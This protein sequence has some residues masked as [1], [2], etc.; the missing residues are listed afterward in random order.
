MK[1][2]MIVMVVAT[3]YLMS[4]SAVLAGNAYSPRTAAIFLNIPG[5]GDTYTCK[6]AGIENTAKNTGVATA[7]VPYSCGTPKTLG[8]G[9][10]GV[11]VSGYR[12]GSYCG[13]TTW[14]YST[15]STDYWQI[16]SYVCS[17][18][19]GLQEF[20]TSASIKVWGGSSYY[21]SSSITSPSQ[22]Y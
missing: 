1:K 4:V 11:R 10:L 22:N 3:I 2:A 8:A 19:S 15:T 14:L 21:T 12:D 17:N 13:S 16:W 20:H 7:H 5:Y 6:L 9:Y 18:P